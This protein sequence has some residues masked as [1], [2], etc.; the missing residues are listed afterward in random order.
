MLFPNLLVFM[1]CGLREA[2]P[3]VIHVDPQDAPQAVLQ[4]V[5]QAGFQFEPQVVPQAIIQT[6]C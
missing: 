6:V 4:A 5:F 3:C 2:D 1:G